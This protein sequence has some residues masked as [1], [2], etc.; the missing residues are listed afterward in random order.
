M[1]SSKAATTLMKLKIK[2]SVG[3]IKSKS[4]L[5]GQL[6]KLKNK[7]NKTKAEI[8]KMKELQ[9]KIDRMNE[10][11]VIRNKIKRSGQKKENVSLADTSDITGMEKG[12]IAASSIKS[13]GQLQSLLNKGK[14]DHL[15][16][17]KVFQLM[18]KFKMLGKGDLD[19][20]SGK[21]KGGMMMKKKN[22]MAMGGL[23]KPAAS[24][25]GLKKLPQSARNNMGYM[26][27]GGMGKKSYGTKYNVG[28]AVK[29]KA[30][31]SIDNRK[32]K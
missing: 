17:D 1:S 20:M 21:A 12:G 19:M 31:G 2:G 22:G 8:K 13:K 9:S 32:K 29:G 10:I 7:K 30:Y 5:R 4:N 15:S 18:M 24:Q 14:L 11:E 6:D 27:G 3:N 26:M 16:N 25:T 28:G 23:K